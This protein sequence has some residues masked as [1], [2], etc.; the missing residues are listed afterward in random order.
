MVSADDLVRYLV[1]N[2]ASLTNDGNGLV[3]PAAVVGEPGLSFR[4]RVDDPEA[5][6]ISVDYLVDGTD[7]WCRMTGPDPEYDGR[8]ASLVKRWTLLLLIHYPTARLYLAD[9]RGGTP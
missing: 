6:L 8:G 9:E 7:V 1:A 5:G 3:V 4:A 2:G